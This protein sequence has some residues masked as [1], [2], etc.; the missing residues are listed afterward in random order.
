MGV[1]IANRL[2][3]NRT[4]SYFVMDSV[5]VLFNMLSVLIVVTEQNLL[6]NLPDYESKHTR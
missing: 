3:L 6:L 4:E 1:M 5:L 2:M